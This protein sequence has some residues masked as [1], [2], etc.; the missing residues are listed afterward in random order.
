MI[1]IKSITRAILMVCGCVALFLGI[2][3]LFLPLLPTTPFILLAA[4]CFS[5]SSDKFYNRLLSNK[6]VGNYIKNYRDGKGIPKRAKVLSLLT[7]WITM[8]FTALVIIKIIWLKILMVIIALAVSTHILSI[9]TLNR[10]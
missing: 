7:L 3:G 9:K 2:A 10:K 1:G 6:W 4:A 8:G 5:R